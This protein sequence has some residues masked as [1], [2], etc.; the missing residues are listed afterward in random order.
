MITARLPSEANN[1]QISIGLGWIFIGHILFDPL[2]AFP[3]PKLAAVTRI[4]YWI[5]YLTGNQVRWIK[6]LHDRYGPVVRFGPNDL[7]YT[8]AQAW[9]DIYGYQKGR[10][11]NPKDPKFFT[12]SRNGTHSIVTV[13]PNKHST[14]RRAI[15]PAFSDRVLV[16]IGHWYGPTYQ[17]EV[18]M[19]L[20]PV[21]IKDIGFAYILYK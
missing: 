18:P 19:Y 15:A 17:Q 16:V 10:P 1:V 3:G 9:R 6:K 21:Y 5:H 2:R 7:S 20:S 11:E 12:I 4:P 8:G 14:L 13:E